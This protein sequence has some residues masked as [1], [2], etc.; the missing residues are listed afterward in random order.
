M[1]FDEYQKQAL[2][3]IA[4]TNKGIDA[5][6]HRSL[7]LSGESGIVANLIKTAIRDN[8]GSLDKA[9]IEDLR[10]RLGDVLY[11]TA[12]L[13]DYF[14]VTLSEIAKQNLKQSNQF[15]KSRTT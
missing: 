3:S 14:D 5:L 10:K 4:I 11:Y 1:D 2:K 8:K 12:A 13:A 7:G 9:G 15:K 6:A